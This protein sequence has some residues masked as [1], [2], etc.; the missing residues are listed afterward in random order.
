VS[1]ATDFIRARVAQ[2]A[3]D[4]AR[5]ACE[6]RTLRQSLRVT[7]TPT[8]FRLSVPHY[9]AKWF[10]DGRGAMTAR[11][12]HKLVY[13]KNPAND[14]RI[15]GGHPVTLSQRIKLTKFEFYRD[16]SAGLLV[17]VDDVGPAE[18]KPFM[19][20]E[21]TRKLEPLLRTGTKAILQKLTREELGANFRVKVTSTFPPG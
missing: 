19:G 13:Y 11:A 2:Q 6:S 14:P 4:L 8:G 3:L 21:L 5:N 16:W 9:W 15:Q 17:V 20:E 12:G 1:L 10:H 18:G 7:L